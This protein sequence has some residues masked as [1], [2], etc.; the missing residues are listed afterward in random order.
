VTFDDYTSCRKTDVVVNFFASVVIAWVIGL[1]CLLN[2][3]GIGCN[4]DLTF[5][6]KFNY[7]HTAWALK[8]VVL[9]F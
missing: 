7:K 8:F 2:C 3:F 1:N 5:T 9:K 6:E 4:A